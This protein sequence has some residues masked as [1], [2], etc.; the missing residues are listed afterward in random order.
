MT[1]IQQVLAGDVAAPAAEVRRLVT[2]L[3]VSTYRM[4]VQLNR[5]TGDRFPVLARRFDELRA[6]ITRKVE[7]TPFLGSLGPVVSLS[8]VTAAMAEEVGQ[9]SAFLGEAQRLLPG[10]VPDGFATTGGAYRAFLASSSLGERIAESLAG[11]EACDLAACFTVATRISQMVENTPLPASLAVA[12]EREARAAARDEQRLA[13]RSSALQEGGLAVSFAGQYRSLLNLRPEGVADAFRQVVA[14]KYSPQAIV[15]RLGRGFDDAE[16]AMCCCVLRMVDAAAAGVLYSAFR[17]SEGVL[18]LLQ[19]VRGLGLSAVD[20]SAEPDSYLLDR[21]QRRVVSH[22]SGRQSAALH[23]ASGEGT[24][25]LTVPAEMQG[26]PVLT[27]SQA[28][29]VAALAWSLEDHLGQAID[30]E[31]AIDGNGRAWVLQVRPQPEHAEEAERP[32]APGIAGAAVLCSGGTRASGGAGC[33]P[34]HRVE[35]DLDMLRFPAGAVL[36]T[37]EASPRLAVLLPKA[38]ALLADLGETTGHLATVARELRV[39]AL[40]AIRE[41]TRR[42]PEGALVTVDADA[43][44]VYAGRQELALARAAPAPRLRS[45]ELERLARVA[46]L[47]LPLTLRDR[48]AS[49]HSPRKCR[50]LHD[51]IRFC[52]QATVEAMFD[53]GDQALRRGAPVHRLI[54]TV[55]IDCRVFDLGGGLRAGAPAGEVSLD[56]V[57]SLPFRALWR[58]LSDPRLRWRMTRPVSLSGFMSALVS[59]NFDQDQRVR[60]MGE[61]SYVFIS[62]DYLNLNSRLGYHFST[63]DARVSAQVESNYASFRF[64]GGSTGVD[65]RSRRAILI[66][67]LLASHGF[68]TDRKADLV[69]ARLRHRPQA[70][71]EEALFLVGLLT[72]FVNHLDMA[73]T[74]DALIGVYE[75]AFRAGRYGFKGAAD[76]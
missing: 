31:W 19:A 16:V 18:T 38:A 55:P 51:L 28:V 53:L 63:V 34:V 76:E 23:C 37:R 60:P 12:L 75:E 69:N 44:L 48:L 65:Q 45:P 20:G 15:Y 9:K 61:P 62:A 21:R 70:E 22:K 3:T 11:L 4:I 68:E 52:H 29:E 58:G 33:G 10:R 59:Y 36:L 66:E 6:G 14:S 5:M 50:T 7:I 35:T 1:R 32:P 46:D 40:L 41:A 57:I 39:P 30:M 73:L 26:L 49:A 47:I 64:V 72:G 54:S 43:A 17:T 25:R 67:R 74:S 42:L 71:I 2:G 56:D 24:K 13:V 8:E 27:P